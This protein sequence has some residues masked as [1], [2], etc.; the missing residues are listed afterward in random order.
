MICGPSSHVTISKTA[1]R[2]REEKPPATQITRPTQGPQSEKQRGGRKE[3]TNT[4]EKQEHTKSVNTHGGKKT[5]KLSVGMR[6][7]GKTFKPKGRERND[8][9]GPAQRESQ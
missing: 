3:A 5:K 4:A 8:N 6:G 1:K 7:R 9:C 2:L